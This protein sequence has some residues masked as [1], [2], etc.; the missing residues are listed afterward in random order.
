M[1]ISMTYTVDAM[2]YIYAMLSPYDAVTSRLLAY[3]VLSMLVW[4]QIGGGIV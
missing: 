4:C 1:T 3:G 2:P